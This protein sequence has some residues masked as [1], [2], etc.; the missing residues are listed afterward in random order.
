MREKDFDVLRKRLVERLIEEGILKSENCIRAMLTVKRHLFVDE[1]LREHAYI[2]SPLPLGDTGQT[3][4]APHMC[5]YLLEALELDVGQTVL[6]IGSGS[7][8][9]AALLAECIA[10]SNVSKEKWGHVITIEYLRKLYE[11]A[12]RNLEKTGYSDRVTCVCGDGTLGYPPLEDRELYDRILITAAAP[13]IPPP[14]IKQLK[15]G[16]IIVCPIGGR[17]MQRLVKI[18]KI[19]EKLVEEYLISCMFVPLRGRYGW[20]D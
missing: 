2:D 1:S 16:G 8:Y 13:E 15:P 7:G 12:K 3:I 14:L 17:F 19:S 20:R 10:P 5:A 6:E 4:S 11:M 9:Q 18:K